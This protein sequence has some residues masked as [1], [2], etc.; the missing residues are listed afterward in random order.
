MCFGEEATAKTKELL[1]QAG[2]NVMLTKDVSETDKYGR[3]LRY[4]YYNAGNTSYM[5]NE[6]L[7]RWGFAQSSTF[8]PDVRYQEVFS[9]L[10][11]EA[12]DS[13]RGLWSSCGSFG[14]P[15]VAPAKA[16]PAAEPVPAKAAGSGVSFVA[17]NGGSPGGNASVTIET[18]PG[19]TCTIQYIVPSGR[20]S[21][22]K[23]LD[24][25]TANSAGRIT[26]SWVI[27]TS[28]VRG[29]GTVNVNCNGATASSPIVI[30]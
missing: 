12:R 17:V 27:G 23:G 11:G 26:W 30:G 5:L 13:K 25:K 21:T 19:T 1:N 28:T 20:N 24:P 22:A 6:E 8:P 4:V 7:V 29:P 18:A 2:G 10:T 16:E 3:L 14:V 15:L 9:K